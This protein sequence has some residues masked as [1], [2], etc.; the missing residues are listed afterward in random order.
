MIKHKISLSL[1]VFSLILTNPS[2]VLAA[3]P[4][5]TQEEQIFKELEGNLPLIPVAAPYIFIAEIKPD[6]T[7]YNKHINLGNEA[8]QK[9]LKTGN[10]YHY[11]TALI[12]YD[13]ALQLIPERLIVKKAIT[14]KARI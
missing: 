8:I 4:E 7:S 3:N 5:I 10:I 2:F 6:I 12:N 13:N 14:V 11:H 1:A 9:G